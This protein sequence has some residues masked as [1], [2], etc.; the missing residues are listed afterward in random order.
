VAFLGAT[1]FPVWPRFK[2]DNGVATYI[3]FLLALAWPAAIVFCPIWLAV[4]MLLLPLARRA[5]R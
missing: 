5:D 1:L 2:G 3:G 4:A